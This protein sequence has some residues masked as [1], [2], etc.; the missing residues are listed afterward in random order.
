MVVFSCD[1]P[2]PESIAV[3]KPTTTTTTASQPINASLHNSHHLLSIL[4]CVVSD[5][6]ARSK[7]VAR[8]VEV[9]CYAAA[10]ANARK[11]CAPLPYSNTISHSPAKPRKEKRTPFHALRAPSV[12]PSNY[13]ARLVRHSHCSRA[14]FVVALLFLDR[15]AARVPDLCLNELNVHRLL[16]TSVLLA[17]KANDDVL[18]DNSH[19]AF[20]S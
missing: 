11:A 20:G 1:A 8:R 18:Y 6:L 19:F 12:S 15:A 16:L 7:F 5:R 10:T 2:K 17:T 14:A 4:D 3:P 13:L 9:A